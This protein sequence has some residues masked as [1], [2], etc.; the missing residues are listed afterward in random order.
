MRL[1][2]A[3]AIVSV[4]V[5]LWPSIAAGAVTGWT[6]VV[7]RIY[8][9]NGAMPGTN[10]AALDLAGR[11]LAAASIDVVWKRCAN[12]PRAVAGALASQT[13][14]GRC[15]APMVPGELAIRIVRSRMPEGYHGTLPLGD[16]LIDTRAGAGVLATIYID[17]VLWLAREAHADSQALLG[18]AI[19]HELGHLLLATSGH[20]PFG[21]MRAFWSQEEVRRGQG[22]D[23]T[24]APAELAAIRAQVTRR[25]STRVWG[26]R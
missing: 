9:A 6:N 16:A 15:D 17:R 23:W 26:T 4:T 18:R 14:P 7:V 10:Q 12:T 25:A 1:R 11:T 22:P 24:F 21:L 8:D 3:L 20:G 13:A 2:Q 19:A 5:L